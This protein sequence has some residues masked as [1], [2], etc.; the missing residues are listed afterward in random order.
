MNQF[1]EGIAATVRI[2]SLVVAAVLGLLL[3]IAMMAA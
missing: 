2:A 3:T 1:I